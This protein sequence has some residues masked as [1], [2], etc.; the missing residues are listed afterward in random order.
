[1]NIASRSAVTKQISDAQHCVGNLSDMVTTFLSF[2]QELST[3]KKLQSADYLKTYL[4]EMVGHIQ[5]QLS[6]AAAAIA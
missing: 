4:E 2:P 6:E 1:M 3:K 5:A